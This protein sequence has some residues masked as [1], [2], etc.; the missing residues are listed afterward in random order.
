MSDA[1][2]KIGSIAQV[3]ANREFYVA[4]RNKAYSDWSESLHR[5]MLQNAVDSGAR[6]IKISITSEAGRGV[7]G[8]PAELKNVT[9][10][11]YEDDGRGMTADVL[12]NVYFS[13]HGTTKRD[14]DSVGGFG[15]ARLM[16]TFSQPRFFIRTG[17][18]WAQGVG[19]EYA[20]R[21]VDEARA[22]LRVWKSAAE[23]RYVHAKQA[24]DSYE[25]DRHR[26]EVE[27]LEADIASMTEQPKVLKGC[28]VELDL[29]V[30]DN[31]TPSRRPTVERMLDT[32]K[33]YLTKSSLKAK[34][35]INGEAFVPGKVAVKPPIK[36]LASIYD[37]EIPTAWRNNP[38]IE[39]M[40]GASGRHDIA[41]G[42]IRLVDPSKEHGLPKGSI[43][44]RS[45]G[46]LMFETTSGSASHTLILELDPSMARDVMTSNR[47]GLRDSFRTALEEFSQRMATDTDEALR[48]KPRSEFSVLAGGKGHMMTI[49]PVRTGMPADADWSAPVTAGFATARAKKLSIE[50]A[51]QTNG[52]RFSDWMWDDFLKDGFESVP[53]T[54]FLSLIKD[55]QTR[56]EAK[57]T[58]LDG[59]H[60]KSEVDAFVQT[61]QRYGERKALTSASRYLFGFIT[62]NLKLRMAIADEEESVR[63]R[64]KLADLNDFPIWK[65]NCDPDT[66]RLGEAEAKKMRRDFAKATRKMDPRNWELENGKG[67]QARKLLA[68]WQVAVQQIVEIAREQVPTLPAFPYSVGWIMSQPT[69]SYNS[70]SGNDAWTNKAAAFYRPDPSGDMRYFLLNPL[71]N[72][73]QLAFNPAKPDDRHEIIA[74][75]AHEVAHIFAPADHNQNFANALTSLMVG[76]T[77]KR[78]RE[79]N[80]EI[81][82]TLRAIDR[83]Y[84]R[85]RTRVVALDNEKGQRPASRF[86][87]SLTAPGAETISHDSAGFTVDC[88][89]LSEVEGEFVDDPMLTPAI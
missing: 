9:R 71:D 74:L 52:K 22:E 35:E 81:D 8:R 38:K 32:L 12:E 47:D 78:V 36:I 54:A 24:G 21:T 88:D 46:A 69:W 89:R 53:P 80:K 6:T 13:M 83:M 17:D 85:G 76:L 45:S 82:E 42:E 70:L 73:F 86:L 25:A 18:R 65:E 87:D 44:V 19:S 26:A 27:A 55:V 1:S 61:A 20:L 41:F 63:N 64:E 84:G 2:S 31:E 15:R 59:Y 28:R 10:V 57:G 67:L 7:L 37:D 49:P 72:N 43:L 29:D 4:E 58:F 68:V 23:Q 62:S 66:E 79:L 34:V 33:S 14:G 39:I 56:G 11:V 40:E 48:G 3:R 60:A 51:D 75:A 30:S 5:E 50:A 77:P 16:T